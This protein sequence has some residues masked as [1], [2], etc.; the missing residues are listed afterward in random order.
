MQD[1]TQFEKDFDF[2][3][4]NEEFEELMNQL[5]KTKITEN[6]DAKKEKDKDKDDSGHDTASAGES[7]ETNEEPEAFYDKTKS[8]FDSISCEAIERSKG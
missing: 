3:K 8:F 4:A 7:A 2:D 1:Q 6:G 5:A